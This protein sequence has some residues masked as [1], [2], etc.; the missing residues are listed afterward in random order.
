M[1]A[2][3]A[4]EFA[5]V[6][7]AD[8]GAVEAAH[9]GWDWLLDGGHFTLVRM[10]SP[11]QT[12]FRAESGSLPPP[13]RGLKAELPGMTCVRYLET[14]S[15]TLPTRASRGPLREGLAPDIDREVIERRRQHAAAQPA[16]TKTLRDPPRCRVAGAHAV[17]GVVLTPVFRGALSGGGPR[18]LCMPLS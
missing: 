9:A 3:S 6:D 14:F 1:A 5:E 17:E 11:V 7:V 12:G 10:S 4:H 15:I 8:L 16:R 2:P 13:A 18:S